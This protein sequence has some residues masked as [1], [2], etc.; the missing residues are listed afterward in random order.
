MSLEMTEQV[1]A[2]IT[3]IESL[4]PQKGRC[5]LEKRKKGSFKGCPESG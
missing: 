2:F 5:D 1:E 3:S 4:S